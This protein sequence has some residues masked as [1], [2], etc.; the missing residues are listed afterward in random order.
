MINVLLFVSLMILVFV[1]VWALCEINQPYHND[2]EFTARERN[3]MYS[4]RGPLTK[5]ERIEECRTKRKRAMYVWFCIVI[6]SICDLIFVPGSLKWA[7]LVPSWAVGFL[8]ITAFTMITMVLYEE[9]IEPF[10]KECK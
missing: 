8:C 7:L 9:L 4:F 5:T 1:I 3:V 10:F 2:Y 6:G